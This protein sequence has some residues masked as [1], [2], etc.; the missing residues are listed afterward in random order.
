M[1]LE[2]IKELENSILAL[3]DSNGNKIEF[4]TKELKYY[5]SKYSSTRNESLTLF[6]DGKPLTNLRKTK[7]RVEYKCKCGRISRIHLSKFLN[8]NRLTCQHCRETEEKR[9]WHSEVLKRLAKGLSY[10]KRDLTSKK[11]IYD[12]ENESDEFKRDYYSR[13][14]THDEFE[15]TLKYIYSID[16]I[17]IADKEVIFNENDISKN[18]KKYRQT[19]LINGVKHPFKRIFL[20]CPLCG[21]IFSITRPIKNRVVANNFDCK[22]CYMNNKI[23]AIKK[24]KNN[25]TYQSKIEL[26]FINR[27]I[28]NNFKIENGTDVPYLINGVKHNYRIDFYL[29]QFRYQVEL[30]DNH[31]WHKHQVEI[32][33]W[34]LKEKAA[35][36]FCSSNNMKYFLLFPKDIDKFF[37]S[38]ERDSLNNGENH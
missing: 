5:K 38:L 21:T 10:D 27:C 18:A 3:F 7:I 17:E 23:F 33:K 29:P 35:K 11:T 6:I 32:G 2:V 34:E 25:L 13:N 24:Y 14:L 30:K 8:K 37:K 36:D 20:K 31:I 9:K 12:F 28:E 4:A 19:V 26:D 22:Y 15:K 1:E 16:N